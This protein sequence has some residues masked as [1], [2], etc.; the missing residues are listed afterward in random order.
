MKRSI[1]LI[2]LFFAAVAISPFLIN[3]KGYILIAMGDLTIESTVVTA[4]IMLVLTFVSLL[5][6]LKVLKVGWNIGFGTWNKIAFASQRRALRAFNKGIAC[7]ILEDYPQAEQLLAKS[8]ES[9]QSPNTAYLLAASSAEK[10][11]SAINTKHYLS[12]INTDESAVKALGLDSVLVRIQ[13]HI[14]HKDYKNARLLMDDYHKHIGHDARLLSLEIDL[15]LIEQRYLTVIDYLVMAR[16]EKTITDLRIAQ[17]EAQAFYPYFGLLLKDS[18]QQALQQYWQS[19][20]RKV[21]QH[22]AVIFAYCRVLAENN[23]IEPLN[24]LLLAPLKKDASV[25]FLK[26]LQSLPLEKADKL[27]SLVQKHLHKDN[28]SAKWLSALGHLA[29]VS[30]QGQMAEKAF[31]CLINLPGQQFDRNDLKALADVYQLQENF[32]QANDIYLKIMALNA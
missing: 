18:D 13:L 17:W 31:T 19:L 6:S 23:I 7:Y 30:G 32:A 9:S 11:S 14:L 26:G 27:I 29:A 15:C 2:L 8:A 22:E 20:A 1:I 10:Q 4:I 16:K 25:N 5:L 12:L 28:H 3:E 21:K 24:D